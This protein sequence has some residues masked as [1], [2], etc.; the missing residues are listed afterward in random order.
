MEQLFHKRMA[1]ETRIVCALIGQSGLERMRRGVGIGGL[2]KQ[3]AAKVFLT[4][5]AGTKVYT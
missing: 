1:A 2:Q 4:Q 5:L 3:A